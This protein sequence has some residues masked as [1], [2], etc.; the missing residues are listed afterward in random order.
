MYV[1]KCIV[2]FMP[3]NKLLALAKAP[4]KTL[5]E[6]GLLSS[7]PKPHSSSWHLA[8]LLSPL[9]LNPPLLGPIFGYIY[10]YRCNKY[11][12][13]ENRSQHN[14]RDKANLPR[15]SEYLAVTENEVQIC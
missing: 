3:K 11:F 1:R 10:A 12:A 2:F 8:S 14:V 4:P 5:L 9:E 15:G 7:P 6:G 13:G